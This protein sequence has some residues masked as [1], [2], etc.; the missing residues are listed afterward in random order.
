MFQTPL[1]SLCSAVPIFLC[2]CLAIASHV[3]TANRACCFLLQGSSVCL[4]AGR[5]HHLT[6]SL[7]PVP[8]AHS[9]LALLTVV[10]H[11]S[12]THYT[13]LHAHSYATMQ[14]LGAAAYYIVH[15][16]PCVSLCGVFPSHSLP[17]ATHSTLLRLAAVL[18]CLSCQTIGCIPEQSMAYLPA[19][20][21][22]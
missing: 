5:P 12:L 19:A 4:A 16:F 11:C 21:K 14:I 10:L 3:R 1:C 7:R 18:L 15:C 22:I 8:P 20:A 2:C 9:S 17:C 13:V 6:F